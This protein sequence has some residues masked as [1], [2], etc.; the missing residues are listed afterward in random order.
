MLI[1][2]YLIVSGVVFIG[3]PSSESS[4]LSDATTSAMMRTA[5]APIPTATP[6]ATRLMFTSQRLKNRKT[7]VHLCSVDQ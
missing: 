1:D 2:I 3:L 6:I 4:F 7:N 5:T